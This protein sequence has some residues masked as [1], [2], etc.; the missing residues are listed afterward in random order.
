MPHTAR[1]EAESQLLLSSAEAGAPAVGKAAPER[2][3][4]VLVVLAAEM[5]TATLTAECPARAGDGLLRAVA[6]LTL[7]LSAALAVLMLVLCYHV[8]VFLHEPHPDDDG[9]YLAALAYLI[10]VP[11]LVAYV[12]KVALIVAFVWGPLSGPRWWQLLLCVVAFLISCWPCACAASGIVN[13]V[14]HP[15]GGCARMVALCAMVA[16]T[17]CFGVFIFLWC[18]RGARGV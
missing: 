2:G 14:R 4:S 1:E 6:W 12:L 7:A 9:Y 17:V 18:T 10:L 15:Y 8:Y 3:G 16:C 5:Q 13:Y 11:A